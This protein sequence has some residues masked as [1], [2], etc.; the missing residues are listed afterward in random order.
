MDADR[1]LD[2]L[3]I[4]AA[5]YAANLTVGLDVRREVLALRKWAVAIADHLGF[6]RP[7]RVP[8]AGENHP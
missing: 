2:L 3:T 7:E 1:L 4:F 5:T 6:K 8:P